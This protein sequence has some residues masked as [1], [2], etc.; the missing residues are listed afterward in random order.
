MRNRS[1]RYIG[2][3]MVAATALVF[4]FV[5]A[6]QAAEVPEAAAEEEAAIRA[7][8]QAYIEAVATGDGE[9]LLGLWTEEGIYIDAS[10]EVFNAQELIRQEFRG[11][12][13]P[14]GTDQAMVD[15]DASIRFITDDVAMEQ[16]T[17][18]WKSADGAES[19]A[20]HYTAIW[21]KRD[22]R[23]LLDSLREWVPSDTASSASPLDDLAWMI[24]DWI[25]EN[26]TMTATCS[27]QWSEQGKFI[28]QRFSIQ[29]DQQSLSGTQY[30]GWDAQARRIRS[31]LFD[32]DGAII[33]GVWRQEGD[34][35]IVKNVGVLA[36]GEQSTSVSFWIP[37]GPNRRVLRTSHIAIGDHEVDEL[38]IEFIRR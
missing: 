25:G 5:A 2:H 18:R 33:E 6:A 16:G 14:A 4:L 36:D 17:S 7:A 23:W 35:W 38:V 37:E 19:V 10:G 27:T 1:R 24:G 12:P 9:G 34:A 3:Q 29:Y 22:G 30:I 26:E 20:G 8:G 11:E 21:V 28:V 13:T 32:S 31:W 15:F